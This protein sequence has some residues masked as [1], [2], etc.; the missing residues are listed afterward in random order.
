M[1][2]LL[3]VFIFLMLTNLAFATFENQGSSAKSWS[4]GG[5]GITLISE[6]SLFVQ[7]PAL[8]GS[9]EKIGF[10]INW[11]RLFEISELSLSE[12]NLVFPFKKFDFGLSASIFGEKDYYQE[13]VLTFGAGYKFPKNLSIGANLKYLR[14]S[15]SPAY[16]YFSTISLDA[17]ILFEPKKGVIFGLSYQN[18]NQPHLAK[19]YD[20]IPNLLSCGISFSL[21][22]D[23]DLFFEIEKE[24]KYPVIYHFGQKINIT[25]FF[26][27][28][29]GLQTQPAR[30]SFG[31]GLNW[32]KMQLDW[33]YLSHPTLGESQK[34]S[35]G[36]ELGK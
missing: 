19:N 14:V 18:L 26:S 36:M 16:S 11:S 12:G 7:N 20:D 21:I 28:R 6:P 34:V 33:A 25:D 3:L 4:L 5:C 2:K 31:F 8:L 27:F 24:K 15:Y 17:G 9:F 29:L 1:K 22:K 23:F 30:Y 10:Q 13:M 32:K 35:W